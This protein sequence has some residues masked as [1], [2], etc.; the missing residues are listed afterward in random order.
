MARSFP[1]LGYENFHI[2]TLILCFSSKAEN[3]F[4]FT[5]SLSWNLGK[6]KSNIMKAAFCQCSV[7]VSHWV[8]LT[9]LLMCFCLVSKW[10]Y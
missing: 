8:W 4:K 10:V 7:K 2:N 9:C 6:S 1:L 5:H 3:R